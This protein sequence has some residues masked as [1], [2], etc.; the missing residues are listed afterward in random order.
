MDAAVAAARAAFPAWRAT[1]ATERAAKLLELVEA[2]GRRQEE[3]ALLDAADNGSPVRDMRIDVAIG[4]A[5]LRY[6]A[7]LA[8]QLRGETI[9]VA[10]RRGSTT[11]CASP[12]ASSAG[13]CPSTTRSCSPTMKIGA[14]LIAG[15]TVVLKPSEHTSLSTL[16]LAEE[17]A[18]IFPPGVVNV[19]TGYGAE[20]GDALVTHPDVPRIAFIGLG[21]D[22][23]RDPGA[24]RRRGDQA[25]DARVR[26]QE[27][28][29]G[30]SRTPISRRRSTA[31][32]AG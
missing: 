15:N 13:S 20:A 14:P 17:L 28:D 11:R 29:R 21:R 5:E 9:P 6:F 10:H 7:G 27:P 24:R 25:R 12:T 2:L 31:S 3:L 30:R 8:L 19:V 18:R 23:P 22:G 26:R 1:P 32:C 16:V 4:M